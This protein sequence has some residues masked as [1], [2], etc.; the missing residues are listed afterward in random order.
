MVNYKEEAEF[1]RWGLLAGYV[2]VREVVAWADA[3]ISQEPAPD[4]SII[5]IALA[6]RRPPADVVALLR[7]VPGDA[8]PIPVRRR[9]LARMRQALDSDPTQGERIARWLYQLAAHGELP[10]EAFGWQA[11]GLDDTFELARTGGYGSY[12]AA[13]TELREYL[14]RHT[15]LTRP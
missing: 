14:H 10:E 7:D 15:V 11:F 12:A 3:V 2:T 1:L 8:D 5:E 4:P 9:L 6:G 13:V